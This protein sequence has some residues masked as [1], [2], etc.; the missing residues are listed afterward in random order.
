MQQRMLFELSGCDNCTLKAEWPKLKN[1]RMP[2]VGPRMTFPNDPKILVVGEAPGENEDLQGEPF[3]GSSGKVLRNA[4][5]YQMANRLF[6][7]NIARCR[8]D[9]N[10]TPTQQEVQCCTKGF[11][12]N[13]LKKLNPH[14]ILAVG[15]TAT[16]YFWGEDVSI[17][18]VRGLRFPFNLGNG[19]WS[20]VFPVMHPS[21]VM[22]FGRKNAKNPALSVF[23]SD[24]AK[25][26]NNL[27]S[28]FTPFQPVALPSEKEVLYPKNLEE[29]K[30]IFMRMKGPYLGFDIETNSLRPQPKESRI[31]TAAFSDGNTTMAFPVS[32]PGILVQWGLDALHWILSQKDVT[33]IAHNATFELAWIWKKLENISMF[34]PYEDTLATARVRNQRAELLS[35]DAQTRMHLGI[36]I[37]D[38][39]GV[40]SKQ[41]LKYALQKVLYYNALDAW[42]CSKLLP[43]QLSGMDQIDLSNYQ[44]ILNVQ[45]STVTQELLGLPIDLKETIKN[46]ES[47][48][49]QLS[50]I[51]TKIQTLPEV[52][53]YNRQYGKVFSIASPQDL[54]NVLV[55]FC[56]IPLAKTDKGN[57]TTAE[58]ELQQF[59]GKHPL[60]DLVGDFREAS[61]LKSTYTTSFLNGKQLVLDGHIYP[62]YSATLVATG[63]LSSQH[64]NAQNFPKRKH[65]YIRKQIKPKEGF[66]MIIC[67]YG[68][69]EARVIAMAAR[70]KYLIQSFI[71]KIDI[72][73]KWLNRLLLAYPSYLDRLANKTG[74]T[75]EKAIRKA[76]RDIIKTDFVFASFYGSISK[77][78]SE[79]TM[80]PLS[81]IEQVLNNEFW[82]EYAPVKNWIDNQFI[83]Y[84]ELGYV[85]TLT[86]LIRN[87]VLPGNEVINTPIQGTGAH[88]VLEAQYAL[89]KR[90]LETNDL[91]LIPRIQIHDDLTFIVP[92]NDVQRYIKII[93]EEMVV[94]RFPW[95]TCPLVVEIKVCPDWSGGEEVAKIEGA[96]YPL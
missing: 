41:I 67:D 90:A 74:Q 39:T 22:R 2:I 65:R 86:G 69:L 38:V 34:I 37:K 53:A 35:L 19:N 75:E 45:R 20:W 78:V 83:S 93:G 23:D 92:S 72:H 26:F 50:E 59:E 91:Y 64:P 10:R 12:Q 48:T 36:F 54:G 43:R 21:Y 88:I 17:S 95:V 77:S 14:V 13:D 89:W 60:V 79:R 28:W 18:E 81:I 44:R 56:G 40:D 24:T 73:T 1:P 25:V 63:R 11:L 57:Y 27:E 71:D 31:L 3:V 52:Q 15:S 42:S 87:E 96:Y 94:P 47:L 33:I 66:V 32:W 8:P 82:V 4:I 58:G 55:N 51:E 70:D 9:A 68:Q 85:K 61:K 16:N 6:W 84:H 29:V 49:V 46:D 30:A 80:I 76:G 62:Q 5:P 7:G